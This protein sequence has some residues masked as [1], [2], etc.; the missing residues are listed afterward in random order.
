MVVN[1][2]AIL[3]KIPSHAEKDLHS[4]CIVPIIDPIAQQNYKNYA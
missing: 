3:K 4:R 2:L 1:R